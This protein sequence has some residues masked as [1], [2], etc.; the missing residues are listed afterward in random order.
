MLPPSLYEFPCWICLVRTTFELKGIA[1]SWL[2]NIPPF[3]AI[4]K[5][6]F[7]T[8]KLLDENL[9]QKPDDNVVVDLGSCAWMRKN[10]TFLK[11]RILHS[12]Q[13]RVCQFED[14][15]IFK[16]RE[17]YNVSC[18]FTTSHTDEYLGRMKCQS[19]SFHGRQNS[20][21][22]FCQPQH[23]RTSVHSIVVEDCRFVY[24]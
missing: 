8:M 9:E 15:T 10:R 24:V 11:K 3:N 12:T 4:D 5:Q 14:A 20:R 6:C 23:L 1:L 22:L 13:T 17:A 18:R 16:V 21:A 2:I 19:I 7:I